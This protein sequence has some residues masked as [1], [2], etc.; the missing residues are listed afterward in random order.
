MVGPL[1]TYWV[2]VILIPL[3][4]V[5]D[6]SFGSLIKWMLWFVWAFVAT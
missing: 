2:A 5:T 1:T 6:W 3:G 4:W